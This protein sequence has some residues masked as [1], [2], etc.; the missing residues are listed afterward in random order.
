MK[1]A[2]TAF[3][4]KLMTVFHAAFFVAAGLV[5]LSAVTLGVFY[6]PFFG[7]DG[8]EPG[9]PIMIGVLRLLLLLLTMATVFMLFVLCCRFFTADKPRRTDDRS[10]SNRIVFST[11]GVILALQLLSAFFLR[12]API[13]DIDWLESYSR[14]II[15]DNSFDCLDSD[16]GRR[17]IVWFPNNIATM[18]LYTLLYKISYSLTGTFSRVPILLFNVLC[19]NSAVLLTVLTARRLFGNRKAAVT[20]T[21]CAFFAPFYTYA[22]FYYSDTF[23]IPMAVGAVY[24]FVAATQ[25]DSRVKKALLLLSC[26]AM[27]C[28]GYKIKGSV[29]ILLPSLFLYLL[30]SCNIKRALKTSGAV[31]LGFLIIYAS[32]SAAWKA[33]GFI[34]EESRE[35]YEFPLTHW[36]M[37]GLGWTGEYSP[38]DFDYTE[39]FD[40]K[41]AKTEA[42]L[43][44]I[45]E[46]LDEMGVGGFAAHLWVKAS[47]IYK[48]GTYNIS[49]Y[50]ENSVYD[51][52]LHSLIIK[53]GSL[54]YLFFA[55]SFACQTFLL[56]MMT[57]SGFAAFRRRKYE[58]TSWLRITMFGVF[59]FFSVWEANPRYLFN[60]TPLYILLATEGVSELAALKRKRPSVDCV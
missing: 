7:E 60:F 59:I 35:R 29:L 4:E 20:L 30:L 52:P 48:D 26:G 58:A 10:F 53:G 31:F 13:T 9:I 5:A 36:A 3:R 38:E 22:P 57:Y 28:I 56:S 19:I 17:Y 23:S 45:G 44:V 11:V 51:T 12:M 55:Y 18:L 15:T 46:R 37:M 1:T 49:H 27:C 6:A 42:D 24:T 54:R 25:T 16:F 39:S 41:E 2:K 43:K 34:S 32:F 8:A 50:L 33:T 14:K 21:I 40:G 47:W